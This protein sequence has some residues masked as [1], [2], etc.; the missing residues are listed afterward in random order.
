MES[1]S[2]CSQYR[3]RCT[4]PHMQLRFFCT[5]KPSKNVFFHNI[6]MCKSRKIILVGLLLHHKKIENTSIIHTDYIIFFLNLFVIKYI[7]GKKYYCIFVNCTIIIRSY[8]AWQT[9][10]K[11][12]RKRTI[13]ILLNGAFRHLHPSIRG[14]VTRGSTKS[15]QVRRFESYIVKHFSVLNFKVFP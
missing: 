7:H 2:L 11:K 15:N 3:H 13:F 14:T 4:R 8:R 6:S 10:P 1:E 9:V 12:L 5:R